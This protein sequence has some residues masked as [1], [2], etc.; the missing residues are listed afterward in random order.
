MADAPNSFSFSP[1]APVQAQQIQAPNLIQGAPQ[2]EPL[3]NERIQV[4]PVQDRTF[5]LL[6]QFSASVAKGVAAQEDGAFVQGAYRAIAGEALQD[7]INEQPK[8]SLIFGRSATVRGAMAAETSTKISMFNRYITDNIRSLANIEPDALPKHL[9]ALSKQFETSDPITNIQIKQGFL[10]NIPIAAR[11]HMDE[12]YKRIQEDNSIQDTNRTVAVGVEYQGLA[13]YETKDMVTADMMDVKADAVYEALSQKPGQ[14]IESHH[15]NFVSSVAQWS[16]QGDFHTIKL[17][18]DAN[19]INTLPPHFREPLFNKIIADKARHARDYR[20]THS[21]AI[22]DLKGKA[23]K[24][25]LTVP[26]IHSRVAEFNAL[27]KRRTGNSEEPLPGSFEVDL[28]MDSTQYIMHLEKE[29][30]ERA[31]IDSEKRERVDAANKKAAE[32]YAAKPD[33]EKIMAAIIGLRAPDLTFHDIRNTNT[34]TWTDDLVDK[35]EFGYVKTMTKPD[36]NNPGKDVV[37]WDKVAKHMAEESRGADTS[38]RVNP[39]LKTFFNQITNQVGDTFNAGFLQTASL[40]EKF[41]TQTGALSGPGKVAAARYLGSTEVQSKLE[42]FLAEMEPIYTLYGRTSEETL[43]YGPKAFEDTVLG[44]YKRQFDPSKDDMTGAHN[45]IDEVA[46]KNNWYG[47]TR[48]ETGW[49]W[50]RALTLSNFVPPSTTRYLIESAMPYYKRLSR[51]MPENEAWIRAMEMAGSDGVEVVGTVVMR[52]PKDSKRLYEYFGGSGQ[53]SGLV[54]R[55]LLG[56]GMNLHIEK[57]LKDKQYNKRVD[58]YTVTRVN[59]QKGVPQFILTAT[60]ENVPK[61]VGTFSGDELANTVRDH[62]SE[63]AKERL[64]LNKAMKDKPGSVLM[65]Y[66]PYVQY[67]GGF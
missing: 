47:F 67:G 35:A 17:V 64:L 49:K 51:Y 34:A 48:P 7:I 29:L 63:K 59:D 53:V 3:K 2:S 52:T 42:G 58:D 11:L 8:W 6:G 36:K 32:A 30:A 9:L 10:Q 16:Q 14:T 33:P 56:E 19:L 45:A 4:A 43:K 22:I 54:T 23:K 44:L 65:P 15:R 46:R 27:F 18:E 26:E 1:T 25:E 39:L 37:D 21:E 31:R 24:A 66:S 62:I 20:D 41:T 57:M 60:S 38:T 40:Y 55:E 61:V 28:A 5:D 13:G 50:N 12:R